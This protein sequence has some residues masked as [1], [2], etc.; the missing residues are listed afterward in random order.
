MVD[1]NGHTTALSFNGQILADFTWSKNGLLV[2][3]TFE[4][5]AAMLTA[6][7]A[8]Q[9][10]TENLKTNSS[11]TWRTNTY[12][13]DKNQQ[14]TQITNDAGT[15]TY[16]YDALNQLVNEQY[17]NGLAISYTYDAVGNRTS[18]T[19]VQNGNT[20]T[21]N[22]SYNNANQMTAA[23]SKTVNV[24]VNGN[25]TNDGDF[26]YVWNAFDQLTEVKSLA[27]TTIATYKY[28]E[29]GRRV[30]SNDSHG[31]TYY[32]YNGVTNQVL[33]EENASGVITKAYTYTD[34]GHPLTMTYQGATY[35][36][37]TNYRGDVLALTDTNGDIVAEYTYDAWGNI[38]SKS[39]A[40]A[41]INPYRYAGYRYDEDT[42]LYY[43]M[44]RYYN[45][46]TGVFLSLDPV[47]GDTM[48]PLSMNGY[49]YANN[50]P[51]MNVDPDGEIAWWI[52]AAIN[53]ALL[54][55]FPM[56]ISYYSKHKDLKGFN[57]N[58][59]WG[60]FAVGA[61][62]SLG[63]AS[64]YRAVA[65]TG[66]GLITRIVAM[67]SYGPKAYILNTV[68]QGKTPYFSSLYK[69]YIQ[70]GILSGLKLV[71]RLKSIYRYGGKRAIN[72][73]LRT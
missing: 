57:W 46:D 48:N 53:G 5:G 49:S 37:L 51:V 63:G 54:N 10:Q 64:F 3:T 29:Q 25:V 38:L 30:Y 12:A 22:Y 39:G 36:Y 34:N 20:T 18:K 9:L 67:T 71:Q 16:T 65:S 23:G 13:Y 50:N 58:K 14:I 61:I 8:N 47:R 6:Y 70:S 31:E 2:N 15:V 52:G 40:M 56:L 1:A 44:A 66:A 21:T 7:T 32:R 42:K 43:L 24:S 73:Y 4:N 62:T 19:T 69:S 60:A 33:F 41:T 35:Y 27:G 72:R 68:A 55:A 28:D 26:Q 45:P 17:S 11:T 59:F